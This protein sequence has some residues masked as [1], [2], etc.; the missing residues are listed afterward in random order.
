LYSVVAYYDEDREI[1]KE[2]IANVKRKT[3][4]HHTSRTIIY[5]KGPDAKS[6][7]TLDDLRRAVGVDEVVALKNVGREGET[8]LVSPRIQRAELD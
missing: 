5:A 3:R 8:Y 4:P 2:T 7:E 6:R 1:L